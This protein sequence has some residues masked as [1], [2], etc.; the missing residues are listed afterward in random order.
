[1]AASESSS[2]LVG[3]RIDVFWHEGMLAHDAGSGV[4]DTG[5]DPGF[6][7][8]L[9]KHPENS[10]RLKNML[11]ILRK[12]PLSPYISWHFGRPAL[13]SELLSFHSQGTITTTACL[14]HN[15]FQSFDL[16]FWFIWV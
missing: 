16:F 7:E 10:D 15:Y 13:I 14:I 1:M 11:S 5:M 9:E 4:F 3:D 8:V 12:G 2:S 6:L